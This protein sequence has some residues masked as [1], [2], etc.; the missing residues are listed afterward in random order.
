MSSLKTNRADLVA[1]NVAGRIAPPRFHPEAMNI[2]SDGRPRPLPGAGGIALGV[3]AGDLA[4]KW[5]GDHLMPGASIEDSV[6]TPAQPGSLHL[7]SCIGNRVRDAAGR[8][9]GVVAGKRGGLAPGFW[10]PQLVGVEVSDSI[11]ATLNCEDRIVVET[12]GRGLMLVDHPDVS[13]SNVSPQLL[14]ALPLAVAKGVL[15]CGVCAL[16]PAE[17]AGSGLGQDSWVG[18]LEITDHSFAADLRF[19]DL[20][21]FA[22]IDST[23]TRYYQPGLVSIGVVS[24]GPG[25]A[26]GHGVGVTILLSAKVEHLHAAV[27]PG[28][29]IAKQ[30]V[31]WSTERA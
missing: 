2:D 5:I 4:T 20:V 27:T 6:A 31:G 17:V 30:L 29:S 11:A 7:L 25:H 9:I 15:T 13:L 1:A 28:A 3:H 23:V 14:D 12:L 19:G 8:V 10:A 21:A 26:P 22:D 18:D 24:H 16:V